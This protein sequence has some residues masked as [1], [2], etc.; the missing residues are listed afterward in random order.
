MDATS[1]VLEQGH[2]VEIESL[3]PLDGVW[4]V[5]DDGGPCLARCHTEG[6]VRPD[7]SRKLFSHNFSDGTK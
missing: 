4:P 2:H 3:T 7:R 6:Q 5:S 1:I